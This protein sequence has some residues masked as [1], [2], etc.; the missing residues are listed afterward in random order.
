MASKL[1]KIVVDPLSDNNPI[2]IQILGIC[3][4][5]AVTTKVDTA[6]V[7]SISLTTVTAFSNLIISLIRNFI[8]S[9]IRI[10][11]ELAV[12]STLVILA[13]Q[14]LKAYVF[15]IS[16]QLSVFVGLIITNCIVLGRLE[17]FAL[18]NKPLPSLLD[19][20]G[21]GLGYSAVL[22]TV[23]SIREILGFGTWHGIRLLPEGYI[24]NGLMLLAP[25]AFFCL[26]LLIW[27]QRQIIR[28]FET[29]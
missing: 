11:I 29:A 28:K 5:L 17:A 24:G 4:A 22:V 12:V 25:G 21:N 19:G 20:I 15:E 9:R 26:G 23:A 16:R 13:D 27:A 18:G 6:L 1:K 14:I 10:I 8:P 7:M 3:S 2:T